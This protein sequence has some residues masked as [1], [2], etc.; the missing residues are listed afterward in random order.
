MD[1]QL[2][3]HPLL[4]IPFFLCWTVLVS[5]LKS[6]DCKCEDLFLD[7]Q[8]CSTALY[9]LCYIKLSWLLHPCNK[10]LTLYLLNLL[11]IFT[12]SNDFGR[13]FWIVYPYLYIDICID[14]DDM[15]IDISIDR[16]RYNVISKS[17]VF[18]PPFKLD[19]FYLFSL[20]GWNL[21]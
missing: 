16:Y 2:S 18:L 19:T 6:F 17:T 1:V 20:P 21:H 12:S 10:L 15:D 4:K 3:Q 11:N 8:F 14:I 13:T 7:S 5:L 9:G